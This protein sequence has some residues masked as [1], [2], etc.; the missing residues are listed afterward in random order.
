MNLE[1]NTSLFRESFKGFNKDDVAAF[2]QKLSKDYTE[3]E[4]KYK[5]KILKLTEENNAKIQE[6]KNLNAGSAAISETEEKLKEKIGLLSAELGE[7][8]A[9]TEKL[10]NLLKTS[11]AD[12]DKY[13][14]DA[15]KLLSEVRSK[16]AEIIELKKSGSGSESAESEQIIKDLQDA[17]AE[18]VNGLSEQVAELSAKIEII[19]G[20]KDDALRSID[21]VKAEKDIIIEDLSNQLEQNKA[22]VDDEKKIYEN[23]TAD[24][25]SIIYSAKKTAE[26]MVE[27]ATADTN[28]M[29]EKAKSEADDI[30][31]RANI[32]KMSIIEENERNI[33]QF[34][35]K[36]NLIKTEHE[37]VMES[38]NALSEKYSANL[39]ETAIA[40]ESI[41]NSI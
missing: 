10:N 2:I 7:L 14:E 15:N 28:D 20:E 1:E 26:D 32:K 11:A 18:T 19:N 21:A 8:T 5:D 37:K 25:G 16:D 30:I 22:K 6:I 36:Y 24:L 12:A 23:I 40:I 27:K 4:E 33:A 35:E 39:L 9:E 31:T 38:F 34:K 29:Y 17:N 3:N 13:K 41:S